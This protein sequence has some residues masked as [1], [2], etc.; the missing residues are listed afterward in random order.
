MSDKPGT[1]GEA[2][3]LHEEEIRKRFERENADG[4][5][6]ATEA[7]RVKKYKE[8]EARMFKAGLIDKDGEPIDQSSPCTECG[9]STDNTDGICSDC[10]DKG[11]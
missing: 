10:Q 2:F 11:L 8:H 5:T 7:R 6:A 4:T 3:D 1:L 9:E